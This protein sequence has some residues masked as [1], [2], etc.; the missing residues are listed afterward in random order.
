MEGPLCEW[1]VNGSIGGRFWEMPF[2]DWRLARPPYNI[3]GMPKLIPST[4]SR[5]PMRLVALTTAA[6]ATLTFLGS[7]IAVFL[8]RA[9]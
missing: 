8:M 2:C 3:V 7:M 6:I 4:R 5:D 1:R 9:P